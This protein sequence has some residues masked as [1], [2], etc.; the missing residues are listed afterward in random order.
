M[1]RAAR[2]AWLVLATKSGS[3]VTVRPFRNED[4]GRI[5]GTYAGYESGYARP[6][7]PK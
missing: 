6:V 3:P 2:A 4:S 7:G 1:P 5:V